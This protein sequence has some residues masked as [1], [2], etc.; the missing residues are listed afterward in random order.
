[1]VVCRQLGYFGGEVIYSVNV[2][3]GADPTW[4]DDV[5]CTGDELKIIEC[6]HAGWG[7]ENCNHGEDVGVRCEV[8]AIHNCTRLITQALSSLVNWE[9]SKDD[10][11]DTSDLQQIQDLE[12]AIN[13]LSSQVST[14]KQKILS[15]LNPS[16]AQFRTWNINQM[17]TWISSLDSGSYA[18]YS[19]KLKDAFAAAEITKGEYLLQ[20]SAADLFDRPFEIANF[21][22]RK[23]LA[24]HFQSLSGDD[25]D[26][27]VVIKQEV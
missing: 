11:F 4:L 27:N 20:I 22:D 18:K 26:D 10:Y 23:R 2:E 21:V 1:M 17:V 12:K 19:Q 15:V 13:Q 3:D 16:V 5:R 9:N 24:A 7:K 25:D 8:P 6:T 14:A